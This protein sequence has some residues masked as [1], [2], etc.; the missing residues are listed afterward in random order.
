ML[1]ALITLRVPRP[2]ALSPTVDTLQLTAGVAQVR[3]ERDAS[4]RQTREPSGAIVKKIRKTP[5]REIELALR[6]AREVLE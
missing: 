2:V 5:Q 4:G 3:T 1:R 6:R